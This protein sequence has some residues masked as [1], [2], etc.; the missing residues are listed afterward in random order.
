MEKMWGI[1]ICIAISELD[2]LHEPKKSSMSR[3][4]DVPHMATTCEAQSHSLLDV[5]PCNILHR[6]RLWERGPLGDTKRVMVCDI[7]IISNDMLNKPL[8]LSGLWTFR[9]YQKGHRTRYSYHKQYYVKSLCVC[10][11]KYKK[12]RRVCKTISGCLSIDKCLHSIVLKVLLL[13]QHQ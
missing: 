8:S 10:V 1:H 9:W 3:M 6:P 12:K 7:L 2:S 5:A 4:L 13:C 11:H